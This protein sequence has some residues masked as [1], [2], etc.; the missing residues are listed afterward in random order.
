MMMLS[1]SYSLTPAFGQKTTFSD[2][3]RHLETDLS[4]GGIRVGGESTKASRKKPICDWRTLG[5]V[6]LHTWFLTMAI[7]KEWNASR[8]SP[9][10]RKR[11][12]RA[13][14]SNHNSSREQ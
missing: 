4:L 10:N 9:K 1:V 5:P 12:V 6:V 7:E 2:G 13:G 8:Y 14:T 11:E 3:R